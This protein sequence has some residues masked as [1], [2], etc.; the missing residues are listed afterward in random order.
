[1]GNNTALNQGEAARNG[2]SSSTSNDYT[3]M[4]DMLYG[5]M[6]S[7]MVHCATK[8]SF[9]EHLANGAATAEAIAQAEGLNADAT[10]RLLRACTT[11]G[12]TTYDRSSGFS[13]T[14]LLM[15]LHR[16]A[17][18]SLRD[19]ALILA[20]HGHW[21][22]WG[23]L[24]EAMK[25]GASQAQATLGTNLWEYYRKPEGMEEGKSFTKAVAAVTSV[26]APEA[27]RTINTKGVNF[28][29]D[30]GGAS[31]TLIQALMQENPTLRGAV[32]D[33]PEVAERARERATA[34]GLRDRLSG[35]AGDFLAE[36]PAADLYLV[37]RIL[38]DW[39]D[40]ECLT[41]LENCRRAL[42]PKGRLI[43][44]EMILDDNEF[45]PFVAHTDLTMMVVLGA[46]ERTLAEFDSLFERTGF[47]RTAVKKTTTPFSIIE[48]IAT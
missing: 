48:A 12:L 28:V 18:G 27:A 5:F 39:P 14:P 20:G 38:C 31:G 15:T 19:L 40:K 7:Q 22:P 6:I 35:V 17:P 33:L 16:D 36:V 44:I 2:I 3:K 47:R 11:F 9:A 1:M 26:V 8:F 34:L 32:L 29:V 13:A 45:T 43:V 42:N 25:T 4:F 24:S 37:Q 41:I 46:K 30:V 23:N 21:S 10:N